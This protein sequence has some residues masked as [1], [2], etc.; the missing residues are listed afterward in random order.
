MLA[1]AGCSGGVL[2]INMGQESFLF[3]TASHF[4]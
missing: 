3:D 4:V 2:R 1:V